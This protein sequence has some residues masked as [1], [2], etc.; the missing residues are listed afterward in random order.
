M[1]LERIPRSQNE[2]DILTDAQY[3]EHPFATGEMGKVYRYEIKGN[4][5]SIFFFGSPHVNSPD[6]YVFQDIATAF[7][8]C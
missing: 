3:V 6:S 1:T 7:Q 8:Q 4:G 2:G 5:K